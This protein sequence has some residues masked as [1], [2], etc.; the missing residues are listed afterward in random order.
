M[1]RR[2]W[3]V[4]TCVAWMLVACGGTKPPAESPASADRKAEQGSAAKAKLESGPVT[5]S[6]DEAPPASPGMK[7]ELPCPGK[8]VKYWDSGLVKSELLTGDCEV[9]GQSYKAGTR[10]EF[11]ENGQIMPPE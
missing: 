7:Q 8:Q 4:L 10:L 1:T 11:D 2:A 9:N 3:A 5:T 6:G